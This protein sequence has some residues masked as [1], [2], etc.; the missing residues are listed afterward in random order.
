MMLSVS[1]VTWPLLIGAAAAA[2]PFVL[3]LLSSVRARQTYFPTLRFL[4]LSMKKTARRRRIQHWALLCL[5][6]ALLALLAVG[7]AEPITRTVPALP[8]TARSK[9]AAVLIIDNSLS[10]AVRN[11][12]P[13]AGKPAEPAARFEKAKADASSLL[14]GG[15]R[16]AL[17]AVIFTNETQADIEENR[18][19][20]APTL[21]EDVQSLIEAIRAGGIS[22]GRADIGDRLRQA[23]ELLRPRWEYQEKAVYVF[24]DLQKTTFADLA[25]LKDLAEAPGIRLVFVNAALGRAR[26]V[27]VADLN[28]KGRAVV[29]EALEIE[30]RLANSSPVEMESI[31]R[32]LADDKPT[33]QKDQEVFVKPAGSATAAFTYT[34]RQV[35]PLNLEVVLAGGDDL[36]E[37]D[38]RGCSVV[39]GGRVRVLVVSGPAGPSDPAAYGPA[40]ALLVA[41]QPFGADAEKWPIALR[42]HQAIDAAKFAAEDLAG[43]DAAFLCDAPALTDRQA[44]A[45]ENFAAGGGTVAIF[46]GPNIL[47]ENYNRLLQAGPGAGGNL[48]PGFLGAP[49]GDVDP[50]AGGK[51]FARLD[52]K[53]RL[54]A[55]LYKADSEY[56][57]IQVRRYFPVSLAPGQVEVPIRHPNATVDPAGDPLL[58]VK[59]L[60]RGQVIL[61]ATSASPVW[62]NLCSRAVFLPMAFRMSLSAA[63]EHLGAGTYAPGDNVGI[64]ARLRKWPDR[65]AVNVTMPN[66]KVQRVAAGGNA[67]PTFVFTRTTQLGR[68]DWTAE[69]A[70][71]DEPG[72]SG[73]FVV[74]PSPAECDLTPVEHEA[75]KRA[76]AGR[77]VRNVY[78]GSSLP[79]PGAPAQAAVSMEHRWWDVL[80]SIV[81]LLLVVEA[82]VANR[83]RRRL[84]GGASADLAPQGAK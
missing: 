16:P 66:G 22:I 6:A 2:I 50:Q 55:D 9:C 31:A 43:M 37:D 44:A 30:A 56:P 79:A 65:P 7:L 67:E 78:V 25:E 3:H 73:L 17:A 59:R 38:R 14:L 28:I 29:G 54:L 74:S 8:E 70:A 53:H 80:L 24:S 1:F 77:G 51:A 41:L 58:I 33:D 15:D 62:S 26:N 49:V 71:A 20:Q 36:A 42:P 13:D 34:A 60:G 64:P 47:A 57:P 10:M 76:I 63:S 35:G 82:V 81:V 83:F 5:R 11:A 4:H 75:M 69:G 61:C 27:T 72:A 52:T 45:L 48:M 40:S 46:L 21:T 39:I 19:P 68:Y 18:P 23:I 32:L 12:S 84:E